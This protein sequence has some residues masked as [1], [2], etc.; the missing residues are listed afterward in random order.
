MSRTAFRDPP[1]ALPWHELE[2]RAGE[3]EASYG[4][5]F[6]KFTRGLRKMNRCDDRLLYVSREA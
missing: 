2:R 4:L 5:E 6:G 1:G 3:L